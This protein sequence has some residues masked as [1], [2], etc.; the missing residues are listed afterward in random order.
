MTAVELRKR[1]LKRWN[2]RC[3]LCPWKRTY[4][5]AHVHHTNYRRYGHELIGIDLLP[6]APGSHRFIHRW[7]GWG[8]RVRTQRLGKYPN[9]LQ[10][11]AHLWCRLMLGVCWGLGG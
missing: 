11:L 7:L 1:T 2:Y 8:D 4:K 9:L 6:L 10:R 3:A 5:Y